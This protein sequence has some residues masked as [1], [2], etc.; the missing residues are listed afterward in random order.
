M[1]SGAMCPLC[2]DC[3]RNPVKSP[4]G[5]S[6]CRGCLL[7]GQG[8]GQGQLLCPQCQQEFTQAS[9]RPARS[10]RRKAERARIQLSRL[11]EDQAPS[12]AQGAG[13][14]SVQSSSSM[15]EV[16]GLY[17]EMLR[18]KL[19]SLQ[20]QKEHLDQCRGVEA[21]NR[22]EL[23]KYVKDLRE[24]ITS[25]FAELQQ[26]LRR[27]EATLLARLEEKQKLVSREIEDNMIKI[28]RDLASINQ[29]IS[30]VESLLDLQEMELLQDMRSNVKWSRIGYQGPKT[31]SVSLALGEF[32]G[33]LQYAVWRRMLKEIKTVPAPLVFDP[34]TAHP[35]LTL[36]ADCRR[37]RAASGRQQTRRPHTFGRCLCALASE[38]FAS[39]TA[40]WEV[41]VRANWE[42]VLGVAPQA[43]IGPKGPQAE[44]RVWA[45]RRSGEEYSALT[46]PHTPL[47]LSVKPQRI[48][49]FLDYQAG[50]LSFYNAD[51]MSH[52]YTFT[53]TFSEELYPYFY[54][55]CKM[56]PLKLVSS[57]F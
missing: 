37:L 52:L 20:K 48:G 45:L 21:A 46:S 3:Y 15:K 1:L 7:Q 18:N 33:P 25:E 2:L 35:H 36:S 9:V 14:C 39:G 10:L 53:D 22:V 8:Q 11:T 44:V 27:E 49:L 29:T 5:H 26:F 28:S 12:A 43:V 23:K 13:G 54:T 47:H 38:G 24:N 19:G 40:Y 4:C 16:A 34:K 31:L 55:G 32:N 6:F 56:D 51:D 42:W 30:K 57:R 50:Q 41:K 17:K